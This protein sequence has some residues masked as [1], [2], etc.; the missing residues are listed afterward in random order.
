MDTICKDFCDFILK[1]FHCFS[2]KSCISG[3]AAAEVPSADVG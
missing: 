2:Q 3:V 1:P